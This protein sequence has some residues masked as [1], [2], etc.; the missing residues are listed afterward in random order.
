MKFTINKIDFIDG[1]ARAKSVLSTKTIASIGDGVELHATK[2][3]HHGL[4]IYAAGMDTNFVGKYVGVVEDEGHCIVDVKK[5]FE[6]L[7]ALPGEIFT[8][9]NERNEFSIQSGK[10]HFELQSLSPE[11]DIDEGKPEVNRVDI[12]INDMIALI[13]STDYAIGGE[14]VDYFMQGIRLAADDETG[15]LVSAIGSDK[16]RISSTKRLFNVPFP[17]PKIGAILSKTG[18]SELSNLLANP[19]K[20]ETFK[21]GLTDDGRSLSAVRNNLTYNLGMLDGEQYPALNIMV[22]NHIA[23]ESDNVLTLDK[24]EFLNAVKRCLIIF[25]SNLEN[26]LRMTIKR[27]ATDTDGHDAV[28]ILE[29]ADDRVGKVHEEVMAKYSGLEMSVGFN[30]KFF[31]DVV[32]NAPFSDS[33]EVVVQFGKTELEAAR[34]SCPNDENFYALLMPYR[35][36]DMSKPVDDKETDDDLMV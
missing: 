28:L 9:E 29:S 7:R 13:K 10:S 26:T 30:A 36:V 27:V 3:P 2:D 17:C 24:K 31:V 4:T 25:S 15:R 8:C 16:L 23:R 1:V 35:L 21:I 14:S 33:K 34:I 5:L 6:I 11:F 20:D 22:D 18:I 12:P 32:D 19:N